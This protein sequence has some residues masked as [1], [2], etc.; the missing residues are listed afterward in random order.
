[1]SGWLTANLVAIAL[2]LGVIARQLLPI[3]NATRV[4][5]A[6]LLERGP[7]EDASWR[8]PAYPSGFRVEQTQPPTEFTAVVDQLGLDRIASDWEKALR[9]AGHLTER[10]QEKGPIQSGLIT[11]YHRI[12]Q[13]YGY[14]ADFTKVFLGLAHAA[15]LPVR[16]WSFS[17]DGFGGHGHVMVEVFDRQRERWLWIDVFNNFHAIDAE[18]GEPLGALSF[19]ESLLGHRARPQL[20]VNGAG[21]PGYTITEKAWDYYVRGAAQW[22][23]WW[24][25]DVVTN[26]KQPLVA[27]AN[28]VSGSLGQVVA[29]ALGT[30][31]RIRIIETRENAQE[32]AAIVRLRKR[33]KWL[34]GLLVGLALVALLQVGLAVGTHSTMGQR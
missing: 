15:G 27:L 13:G 26:D 14:C 17:F 3:G 33:L 31:P 28:R 10:A 24:G 21:R 22:Y 16:Q 9:L 8:P 25:N 23:L 6:F 12:R 32:V 19:R 11:T 2:V 1:M 5:N 34:I 7:I 20:V 30:H 29:T 4:R 18:S